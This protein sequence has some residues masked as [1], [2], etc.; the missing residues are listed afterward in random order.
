MTDAKKIYFKN[1]KS[2]K[3]ILLVLALAAFLLFLFDLSFGSVK[4]P[5]TEVLHILSGGTPEKKAWE[6]IV[7]DSRLPQSIMALST[8]IALGVS[9]L[10]LQTYFRNPLAGPS[11]LGITSGASLG[12][13][14]FVLGSGS[15][16]A[17][18]SIL[19]QSI[20]L[21][22]AAFA[23]A[24]GVML[25]VIAFG[26]ISSSP[27]TILVA[28]LMISHFIGA[29]VSIFEQYSTET[30]LQKFVFWGFGSFSGTSLN[31]SYGIAGVMILLLFISGILIKPLNANILG[32]QYARSMGVSLPA[33]RW[34]VIFITGSMA[35]TI[36]AFCGPIAF[37][38]MAVPHIARLFIRSSDHLILIPAC[39]IT[40]MIICTV[41]SIITRL[42]V[43]ESD[44][45][46]NA[47]TSLMGAPIVVWILIKQKSWK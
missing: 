35:A 14:F 46:L 12:V 39:A 38:G 20:S 27:V 29:L 43:F 25:L 16:L 15:M 30:Q 22:L 26:R 8:G 41:C 23:G 34:K 5:F 47:V 11:V 3:I 21:A 44:L 17:D 19:S 32:D 40:G 42:P 28:G 33:F 1:R 7:F 45:P 36:T 6:P 10:I 2:D 13:A 4:I 9:G 31:Q 37:V 18:L 24:M